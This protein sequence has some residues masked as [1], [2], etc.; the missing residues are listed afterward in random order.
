[1]QKART[2]E[3]IGMME[4]LQGG[5][6]GEDFLRG[7]VERYQRSEKALVLVVCGVDA[8]GYREVLGCWVAESES[9]AS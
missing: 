7:L 9:E 6:G 2:V 4:G 1:M 8:R 5:V 3:G